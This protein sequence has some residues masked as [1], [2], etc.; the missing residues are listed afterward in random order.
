MDIAGLFPVT[1]S[2]NSYCLMVGYRNTLYHPPRDGFI[3]RSF[4]TL[5]CCLKAPCRETKKEWDEM[6][7]LILMRY[8]HGGTPNLM[9]LGWQIRIAIQAIYGTPLDLDQEEPARSEYKVPLQD[10]LRAAYRDARASPAP[11]AQLPWQCAASCISSGIKYV[12]PMGKAS[13][14]HKSIGLRES[15]RDSEQHRMTNT[16]TT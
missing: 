3:Q 6:V 1:S 10:G 16:S 12:I 11:T 7:P 8:G 15:G 5:G 9:M 13:T 2:G 14:H 4:R